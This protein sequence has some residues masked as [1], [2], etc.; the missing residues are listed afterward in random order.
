MF[1]NVINNESESTTSTFSTTIYFKSNLLVPYS[2][3]SFLEEISPEKVNLDIFSVYNVRSKEVHFKGQKATVKFNTSLFLATRPMTDFSTID[4][5][6]WA[7]ISDKSIRHP[8][9]LVKIYH[10]YPDFKLWAESS[11]GTHTN[12]YSSQVAD[13]LYNSTN[14]SYSN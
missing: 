14:I 2:N 11:G 5:W 7:I 3:F 10:A 9:E 8:A 6:V 1:I 13:S 12:W 4:N